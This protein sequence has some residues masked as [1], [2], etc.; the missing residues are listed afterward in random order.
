MVHPYASRWNV[1]ARF[2]HRFGR[3]Y[4]KRSVGFRF[5]SEVR[6]D[7]NDGIDVRSYGMEVRRF[8]RGCRG[9]SPDES[10]SDE[11][12]GIDSILVGSKERFVFHDLPFYRTLRSLARSKGR[13]RRSQSH[14]S[15]RPKPKDSIRFLSMSRENPEKGILSKE[16]SFPRPLASRRRH[17]LRAS[18]VLLPVDLSVSVPRLLLRVSSRVPI[19]N[20]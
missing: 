13:A 1:S 9:E 15:I 18:V 17:P 3:I 6:R 7:A 14:P 4:A 2:R 10:C 19:R 11:D 16:T 8:E 5:Q 12:G 20:L